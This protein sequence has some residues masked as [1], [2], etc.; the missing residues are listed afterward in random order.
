MCSV[1]HDLKAIFI[2]VH[3]TGGT[4]LSYMLH[5]YYGFK[6]YYL[7]RP[8]HDQFCRNTKKTTKYIN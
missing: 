5:K 4:Y 3:K 1:N 6:N 8:D 7:H 2:H